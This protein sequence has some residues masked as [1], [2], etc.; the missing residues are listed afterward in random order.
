MAIHVGFM[1]I[2]GLSRLLSRLNQGSDNHGLFSDSITMVV[3]TFGIES[4]NKQDRITMV[5][6]LCAKFWCFLAT[7][8]FLSLK[9]H[10]APKCRHLDLEGTTL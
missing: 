2:M 10:L 8:L 9:N 1:T 7:K 4:E 3:S 5:P 6:L